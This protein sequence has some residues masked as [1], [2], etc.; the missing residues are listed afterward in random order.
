MAETRMNSE[1][2]AIGDDPLGPVTT[3]IPKVTFGA[4][5]AALAGDIGLRSTLTI[6]DHITCSGITVI[7]TA[8]DDE[9]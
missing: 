7:S 1:L 3:L 8:Q 5:A 6:T 4:R 9:D 2:A